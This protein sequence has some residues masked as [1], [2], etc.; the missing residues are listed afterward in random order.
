MYSD[1]ARYTDAAKLCDFK[2]AFGDRVDSNCDQLL[3][4]G[5]NVNAWDWRISPEKEMQILTKRTA[6]DKSPESRWAA[7]SSVEGFY[8]KK[9][10]LRVICGGEVNILVIIM[11]R[12]RHE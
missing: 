10:W 11:P 7:D 1:H 4:P 3:N 6:I 12:L 9:T 2:G 5:Y 8:I